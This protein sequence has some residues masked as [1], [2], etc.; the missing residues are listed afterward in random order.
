MAAW[1]ELTSGGF[2]L[3]VIDAGHFFHLDAPAEVAGLLPAGPAAARTPAG[4]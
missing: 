3:T 2:S 1:R 4:P